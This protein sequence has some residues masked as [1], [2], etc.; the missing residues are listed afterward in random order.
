[1][2]GKGFAKLAKDTK[3]IDKKLTATDVDLTF[4]KIKERTARRITFDQFLTG[5]EQFAAKK[6]VDVGAVQSSVAASQ[7]PILRG[8]AAKNVR[9]H[10]DTSTYTG[11]YAQG[12][13]SNVDE[14]TSLNNLL[15]RSD[16]DVRGVKTGGAAS[17][18]AV[19]HGVAGIHL[20][21]ESKGTARPAAKKGKKKAGGAAA[22][23]SAAQSAP[24]SS[25]EQVFTTYAAGREMDGKTFA[26]LCKD[27]K[28]INKVCT[29][30]DIDLIFARNKE[31]TA[32]KI[33]YQQ[34]VACVTDVAKKRGETF[35]ADSEKILAK[36][37]P[38]FSGTQAEA[39]RFHDDKDQYTGVLRMVAQAPL[40]APVASE[41][42]LSCAIVLALTCAASN[43]D[44]KA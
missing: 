14:D 8:T 33:T 9:L 36:G 24:A 4:N 1:M 32:R 7:G 22:S 21:E 28:L 42:S 18:A 16:A 6:Q 38:V 10:D 39:V 34:F 19:T 13:P 41:T 12:G 3:L 44:S 37:G 43:T 23:E 2:D 11:V 20:V 35:E 26:K 27:C 30:T 25:L 17:V 40:A 15:D 29:N 31:R 5:L